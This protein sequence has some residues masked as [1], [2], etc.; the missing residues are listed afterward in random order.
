VNYA[1]RIFTAI[2]DV[3]ERWDELMTTTRAPVFFRRSFLRAFEKCPLHPVLRIAYLLVED[4]AGRVHAA[5]PAYLQRNV[6]PMRVIADHYP[7]AVDQTVLL[8]HVWHC[9]DT[10]LPVRPGSEVAAR[11]AVAALRRLAGEWEAHLYGM[12]NVDAA[13]PLNKLLI[14]SGMT[15]IDIDVGWG[16]SLSQYSGFDDYVLNG[17]KGKARRNLNHDLREADNARI[18][19]RTIDVEGADLDTFVDLARSTAAKHHNSDYYQPGLFQ[20]F[21]LGLG[22]CARVIELRAD[23]QMIASAIILADDT[24]LHGWAL[25]YRQDIVGYSPFYVAFAHVMR[26][27]W[28]SG[29][30]WVELGRRNPTFK[31]R[32]GLQ[33]RVLRAYFATAGNQQDRIS[34]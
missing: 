26:E 34:P 20:E 9:Y 13:S 7:H 28:A 25:G 31:Q 10:V 5:L 12:V 14:S 16:L 32:Y 17:L 18:A 19:G 4:Q 21:V 24:R 2:D 33:P 11:H 15:N 6:D 22:D 8:S 1:V 30:S 27:A 3:D 23:D 29:L